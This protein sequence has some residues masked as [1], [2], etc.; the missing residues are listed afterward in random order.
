MHK[1]LTTQ[2][3]IIDPDGKGVDRAS[4]IG[5]FSLTEEEANGPD[6]GPSV[7][8]HAGEIIIEDLAID[9]E[10]GVMSWQ[11]QFINNDFSF[12]VYAQKGKKYWVI[13]G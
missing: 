2:F 5:S 3:I 9:T 13:P 4:N 8:A 1:I 12:T 7:L 10:K 11:D 6:F